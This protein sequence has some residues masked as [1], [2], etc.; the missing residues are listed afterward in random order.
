MTGR[1]PVAPWMISWLGPICEASAD[2]QCGWRDTAE[3]RDCIANAGREPV[4]GGCARN[5]G[6][7]CSSDADCAVGGCGGEVCYNPQLSEG[8]STCDC[9]TPAVSGCGCV[10]GTCSWYNDVP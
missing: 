8:V 3:L 1:T 2:G 4:E 9:S 7:A 10:N 6:D 5:N